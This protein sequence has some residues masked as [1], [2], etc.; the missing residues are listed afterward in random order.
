MSNNQDSWRVAKP[1]FFGLIGTRSGEKNILNEQHKKFGK[2]ALNKVK[3]HLKQHYNMMREYSGDRPQMSDLVHFHVYGEYR[4]RLDSAGT[5]LVNRPN[6]FEYPITGNRDLRYLQERGHSLSGG[7]HYGV[8]LSRSTIHGIKAKRRFDSSEIDTTADTLRPI[9]VPFFT[10]MI[11]G[12]SPGRMFFMPSIGTMFLSV[13]PYTQAWTINLREYFAGKPKKTEG[14]RIP[15]LYQQIIRSRDSNVSGR[16]SKEGRDL[17]RAPWFEDAMVD[18]VIFGYVWNGC[19]ADFT[20]ANRPLKDGALLEANLFFVSWVHTFLHS[21]ESTRLTT[22]QK[23]DICCAAIAATFATRKEGLTETEYGA[24][25]N[26]GAGPSVPNDY[27]NASSMNIYGA[28]SEFFSYM[29]NESIIG[30]ISTSEENRLFAFDVDSTEGGEAYDRLFSQNIHPSGGTLSNAVLE[31]ISYFDDVDGAYNSAGAWRISGVSGD[32]VRIQQVGQELDY[33]EGNEEPIGYLDGDENTVVRELTVPRNALA[34]CDEDGN[35]IEINEDEDE[36]T[37]LAT[38]AQ[39]TLAYIS[40]VLI[41]CYFEMETYLLMAVNANNINFDRF[42]SEQKED[43]NT[44]W[45][46]ALSD[47]FDQSSG[48][49]KHKVGDYLAEQRAS[50]MEGYLASLSTHTKDEGLRSL[51]DNDL[52]IAEIDWYTKTIS[53]RLLAAT[54]A[55]TIATPLATREFEDVAGTPPS[56][57]QA[58]GLVQPQTVLRTLDV[59]TLRLIMEEYFESFYNCITELAERLDQNPPKNKKGKKKKGLLID[60]MWNTVEATVV[61]TLSLPDIRPYMMWVAAFEAVERARAAGSDRSIPI[62]PPSWAG[63]HF[64]S[65]LT[66]DDRLTGQQSDIDA[67]TILFKNYIGFLKSAY[68][69][70]YSLVGSLLGSFQKIAARSITSIDELQDFF[71]ARLRNDEKFELRGNRFNAYRQFIYICRTFLSM[72]VYQAALAM[73]EQRDATMSSARTDPTIAPELAP[74]APSSPLLI[75][76]AANAAG[77]P[78]IVNPVRKSLL[79]PNGGV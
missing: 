49:R 65:D 71:T 6:T 21:V 25:F 3:P 69:R 63:R 72:P 8:N 55:P 9:E 76:D 60:Q 12:S 5:A 33:E 15:K 13:T 36:I 54:A 68:S 51:Y 79:R 19:G 31:W 11:E 66:R 16:L 34:P 75:D 23:E 70:N 4:T 22:L 53:S 62:M 67:S 47:M 73:A 44:L 74:D 59:P 56:G 64:R 61:T 50:L 42:S 2:S 28:C 43:S 1:A 29:E 77:I 38:N 39:A 46:D 30:T 35:I 17:F 45:P 10:T 52:M 20:S 57:V 32:N 40:R 26:A 24:L 48:K 7:S 14:G 41:D 27:S 78:T 37:V 58:I 18:D